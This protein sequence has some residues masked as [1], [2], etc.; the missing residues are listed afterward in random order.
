MGILKETPHNQSEI[1]TGFIFMHP[2]CNPGLT[3]RLF[4]TTLNTTHDV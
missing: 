1:T 2:M 3:G 4:G